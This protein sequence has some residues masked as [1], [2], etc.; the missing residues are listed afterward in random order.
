MAS[1]NCLLYIANI[2]GDQ[3]GAFV[4]A[5][6]MHDRADLIVDRVD[7]D[8]KPAGDLLVAHALLEKAQYLALGGR[9]N[10]DHGRMEGAVSQGELVGGFGPYGNRCAQSAND[11]IPKLTARVTDHEA[12][13][14][15]VKARLEYM[16]AS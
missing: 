6:L 3:M 8:P 11:L 9:Q 7:A 4:N 5:E 1:I 13:V 14:T 12:G 16:N 10:F 15:C 2:E